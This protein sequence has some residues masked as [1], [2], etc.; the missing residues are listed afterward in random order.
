MFT[1]RLRQET[2]RLGL[3]VIEVD[4]T[5]TEEALAERVTEAFGLRAWKHLGGCS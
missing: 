5:M 4:T 2:E 3:R 1:G